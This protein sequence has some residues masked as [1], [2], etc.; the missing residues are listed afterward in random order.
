M[1]LDKSTLIHRWRCDASQALETK[2]W[3]LFTKSCTAWSDY[4]RL[5]EWLIE[6]HI[7]M[8]LP[9][10]WVCT[11]IWFFPS[12]F[13]CIERHFPEACLFACFY[14]SK[15]HVVSA[16]TLNLQPRGFSD[17]KNTLSWQ[18]Q[19]EWQSGYSACLQKKKKESLFYLMMQLE[20]I[21]FHISYWISSTWS[22]WYIRKPTVTT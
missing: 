19:T 2:Y 1:G 15:S 16:E 3:R 9:F 12:R 21:D 13:S 5:I 10:T 8:S 20:H 7:Y 6:A 14:S 17:K 18:C 4:Y 11:V 22:L